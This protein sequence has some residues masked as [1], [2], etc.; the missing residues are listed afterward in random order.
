MMGFTPTAPFSAARASASADH[1]PHVGSA[2]QMS[3]KTLVSTRITGSCATARWPLAWFASGHL[4][5]LVGGQLGI[6]GCAPEPGN[7]IQTLPPTFALD[8]LHPILLIRERHLVSCLPA[9]SVPK[10]LR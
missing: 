5:Q 9:E 7:D 3:T 1:S 8:D 10:F 6:P 2:V 4:H